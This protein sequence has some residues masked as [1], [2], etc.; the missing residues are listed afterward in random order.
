[1]RT[2]HRP[3]SRS[4]LETK[5]EHAERRYRASERSLHAYREWFVCS[6]QGHASTSLR[7]TV[8]DT[9]LDVEVLGLSRAC[10]GVCTVKIVGENYVD[11]PRFLDDL[12]KEWLHDCVAEIRDA[13]RTLLG[14][15]ERFLLTEA[16]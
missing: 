11:Q 8:G 13:A 7:V 10:G 14:A 6:S 12:C 3:D 16:A 2:S 9:T 5:L 1:M 15:R 4:N